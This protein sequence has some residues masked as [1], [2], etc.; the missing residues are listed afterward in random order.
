M[1]EYREAHAS[2]SPEER[3]MHLGN[4]A[5]TA[6]CV[7]I[8][9][10][11][12]G[13]GLTAAAGA[14]KRAGVTREKLLLATGL[15]ALVFGAQAINVQVAPGTSAHLVGGVL[16][17]ALLGPGLGALTMAVV[18]AIQAVMLGDGGVAAWGANVINM[19]LVPAGLVAM[20]CS[21]SPVGLRL[22]PSP[23]GRGIFSAALISG[24][25]VVL[26]AA[27]IVME[28][29]AFRTAAEL[30]GWSRFAAMML[31]THLWVGVLE[32]VMTAG[33]LAAVARVNATARKHCWASQQWHPAVAWVGA[34][35]VLAAML[36]P[37]SS[38]LPDGYE[39]A[40]EKSGMGWLLK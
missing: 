33:I 38:A 35:L 3:D 7:A 39:A 2:R 25:A 11:A 8:T 10:G 9:Y 15:G 28:T 14:A 1:D 19:G 22:T 32:G 36:L 16:L 17:A 18:L 37:V 4:G 30:A 31:G 6:E 12:A 5:I 26:A 40:A 34:A 24:L 20:F 29:A 23:E 21:P 13:L 27:L